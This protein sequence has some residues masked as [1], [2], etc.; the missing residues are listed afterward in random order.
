MFYGQGSFQALPWSYPD[1]AKGE[2]PAL[3]G[4]VRQKYLWQLKAMAE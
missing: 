3:L 2:L 1:Y 4:L